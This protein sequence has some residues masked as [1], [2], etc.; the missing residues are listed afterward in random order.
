MYQASSS[1]SIKLRWIAVSRGGE[2]LPGTRLPFCEVAYSEAYPYLCQARD[3][4]GSI[5]PED[6]YHRAM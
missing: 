2:S 3:Q 4:I 5:E 1:T 6:S